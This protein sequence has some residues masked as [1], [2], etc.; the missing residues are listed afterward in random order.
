M[1]AVFPGEGQDMEREVLYGGHHVGLEAVD[2]EAVGEEV[3]LDEGEEG[4]RVFP[5]PG[6]ED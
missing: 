3:D 5:Y 4:G 6:W 2:A 1:R